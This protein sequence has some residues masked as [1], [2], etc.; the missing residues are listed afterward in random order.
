[1]TSAKVPRRLHGNQQRYSRLFRGQPKACPVTNNHGQLQE[2]AWTLAT[3]DTCLAFTRSLAIC[4]LPPYGR[5]S[6]EPGKDADL[7]ISK[8]FPGCTLFVEKPIS[9]C[10]DFNEVKSIAAQ[11]QGL[12][13]CGYMF[14]YLKGMSSDSATANLVKVFALTA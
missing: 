9:S 14:R 10:Q 6:A 4:G 3:S 1:M 7:Q 5:G 11:L 13:S 2:L 12:N 8:C